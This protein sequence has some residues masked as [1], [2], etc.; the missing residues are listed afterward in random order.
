MFTFFLAPGRSF[1]LFSLILGCLEMSS[2]FLTQVAMLYCILCAAHR[3][4]TSRALSL[5]SCR[6]MLASAGS[7]RYLIFFSRQL[8]F[9]FK[10]SVVRCAVIRRFPAQLVLG[11]QSDSTRW[12]RP[13]EPFLS[14][15]SCGSLYCYTL[16][17]SSAVVGITVLLWHWYGNS[18][19]P[20]G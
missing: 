20:T 15:L 5:W 2:T 8:R 16:R 3:Y 11:D 9:W 7:S 4:T 6:R 1:M 10:H 14:N 17:L 13:A 18:A 12:Q 19:T